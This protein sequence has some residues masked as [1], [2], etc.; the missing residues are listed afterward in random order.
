MDV[1]PSRLRRLAILLAAVSVATALVIGFAAQWTCDDAFISYR[2]ALNL[3]RGHGLVFNP[4]EWVEGYTNLSWTLLAAVGIA[5]GVRVETWSNI[6]SLAAYGLAVGLLARRSLV[7]LKRLGARAVVADAVPIAALTAAAHRQWG[8]WAT[9]GL[10]TS[11]FTTLALIGLLRAADPDLDEVRPALVTGLVFATLALTRPDGVLLAGVAG[12]VV[13]AGAGR[14]LEVPAA[15]LTG[16]LAL[17][18]PALVLQRLYYG[19]WVPNTFFAKS[20]GVAWYAQGVH[21]LELFFL[22]SW[23]VPLGVLVGVA[24]LGVRR[25][26]DSELSRD[27]RLVGAASASALVYAWFVARVG[28]DFMH[29]RLLI[30]VVP[31]GLIALEVGLCRL[32]AR[33][34]VLRLV[35]ASVLL[36]AMQATPPPVG[37]D[38]SSWPWGISDEWRS[39][40][41]QA[42][43]QAESHGRALA[44]LFAGLP[45]RVAFIGGE[46]RVVYYADPQVAIE[47]ETGLTDRFI[48]RQPLERRGRPG[49]E[50]IAP[51]DYLIRERNVNLV[52]GRVAAERLHLDDL[53]PEVLIDFGAGGTGRLL[54]WDPGLVAELSHRGARVMDYPRQLDGLLES[55]DRLPDEVVVSDYR[56]ARLFYFDHVNDPARERRFRA[57][58]GL[59]GE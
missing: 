15:L 52:F 45:V 39:Y 46:A 17:W 50:K 36:F 49:H 26:P 11:A 21:Y 54:R 32:L 3:V 10:E 16:F 18:A 25:S 44:P 14:R 48:A 19:E 33:R 28:G 34:S 29:A 53:L 58:L 22:E 20:A 27:L 2:Y 7:R 23:I 4:G 13:L 59:L 24:S 35:T 42:A 8:I 1:Y 37:G 12:A 41:P 40:P 51:L 56:K 6:W 55:L 9:G 57:R 5:T 30:P 38:P 47:C 43:A 31:F